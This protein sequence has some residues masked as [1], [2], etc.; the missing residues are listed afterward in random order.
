MQ[1]VYL[2]TS[3]A[4]RLFK[5]EPESAALETWLTTQGSALVLTSDL[6]RTELRRAM[7]AAGVSHEVREEAEAWLADCALL[8]VAPALCDRAGDLCPATRLRSLD[9]LHTAAALSLVPALMAFVTYDERLAEV[10]R[11]SGLPVSS[12]A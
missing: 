5:T 7:H 12:P 3:A 6:T 1:V 10:A 4:A 8:R 11:V 9:A 2:D